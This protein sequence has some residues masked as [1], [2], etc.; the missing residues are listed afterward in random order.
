MSRAWYQLALASPGSSSPPLLV[1]APG[2]HLGEALGLVEK[3]HP[4]A[5]VM[6]V[7]LSPAAPLGD[8]VGK[9]PRVVEQGPAAE[10]PAVRFAWPRGVLPEMSALAQLGGAV[11]GYVVERQRELVTV[12]AQVEQAQLTDM[13]LGLLERLPVADNLEVRV[14][15]HFEDQAVTE[16]WL[17]PRTGVKQMLRFLD[18]QDRDLLDSGYVELAVYLRNERS[19]LRLTEHKTVVWT[20]ADPAT[21]ART[22]AGLVALRVPSRSQLTL[23]SS[24]P[25]FHTRPEGS[26]DRAALIKVLQKQRMRMVDRLDR[27][28]ASL[29]APKPRP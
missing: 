6:A 8:S 27:R 26:R 1:E 7:R 10:L 21:E 15:H 22:C 23:V 9:S 29:L 28:G 13:F 20:S 14:L 11:A 25:H 2:H 12:E 4:R 5:T 3:A 16:V 24:V 17:T 18:D 19:T